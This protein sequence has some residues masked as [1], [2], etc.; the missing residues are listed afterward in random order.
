MGLWD[1]RRLARGRVKRF[2]VGVQSV[3]P[4]PETASEVHTR[5]GM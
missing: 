2:P 5:G 3:E 1:V 4:A